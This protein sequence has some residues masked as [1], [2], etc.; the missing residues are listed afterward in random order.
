MTRPW[1]LGPSQMFSGRTSDLKSIENSAA[2]L[3]SS[4]LQT[5]LFVSAF[6]PNHGAVF[7]VHELLHVELAHELSRTMG[8]F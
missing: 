2:G 4:S 5:F 6:D 3:D 7:E 8:V 1:D